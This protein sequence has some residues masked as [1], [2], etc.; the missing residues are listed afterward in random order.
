MAG[1]P[2]FTRKWA[3]DVSFLTV[4]RRLLSHPA[5]VYPQFATHNAL[6]VA[7]I[8]EFAREFSADR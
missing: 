2:V 8:L 1:F 7:S 6:T 5:P 4:A 3:T